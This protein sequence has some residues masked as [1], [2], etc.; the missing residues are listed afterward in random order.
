MAAF[1]GAEERS[2][3]RSSAVRVGFLRPKWSFEVSTVSLSRSSLSKMFLRVE[4]RG[5]VGRGVWLRGRALLS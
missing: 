3:R 4:R 5:G 1:V 2:A